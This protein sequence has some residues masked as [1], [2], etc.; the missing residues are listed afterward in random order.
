LREGS[1]E[2]LQFTLKRARVEY[3]RESRAARTRHG[4]CASSQFSETTGDDL[5]AALK[6]LR[7]RNGA[8]LKGLV[9]DLRNNPGG[10]LE[11]AVAVSDTF[12]T[13]ASS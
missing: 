12:S 13:R 7:K 5:D 1:A 2:P 4:V 3:A 6:D 9:L 10:V 11:A 8:A